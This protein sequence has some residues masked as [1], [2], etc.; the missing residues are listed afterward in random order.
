MR[1]RRASFQRVVPDGART[2]QAVG[3][4]QQAHELAAANPAAD[5]SDGA[6]DQQ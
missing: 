6:L 3:A 1:A 2:Q 5:E 4:E